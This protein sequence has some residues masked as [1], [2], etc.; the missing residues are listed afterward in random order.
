MIIQKVTGQSPI[1]EVSHRIVTP[2]TLLA[3][4]RWLVSKKWTYLNAPGRPSVPDEI[5]ALVEQPG[6]DGIRRVQ[7]GT[8]HLQSGQDVRGRRGHYGAVGAAAGLLVPAQC[9]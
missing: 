4:H 7:L 2:D 8:S 3:W 5:H 6:D 1:T 9:S